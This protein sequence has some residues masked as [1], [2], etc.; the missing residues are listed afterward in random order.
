MVEFIA[1]IELGSSKITGIVGKKNSDESMQILAYAKENIPASIRKGT[2]YNINKTAQGLTAIINR[3][4]GQLQHSIAK[5]YVGIS[6][7]SLHTVENIVRRNL[8]SETVVSE[9]LIHE[10]IDENYGTQYA[11]ADILDVIPQE[12]KIGNDFQV[13]PVGVACNCIEGRFLNIITRSSV[14]KNLELSFELAKIDIADVFVTPL[15]TAAAI[16]TE[17]EKRSGCALVDFGADTTTVAIYKN[18]ILRFLTVLPLGSNNITR[19][20][21]SLQVEENEAEHIKIACGNAILEESDNE[22]GSMYV[23]ENKARSIKLSEL[24]NVVEARTEEI[25]ANV[26]NQ[27][28]YSDYGDKL[29]S[30]IVITGGGANLKN[31]D[32]ALR[33]KTGVFKIR[34]ANFVLNEIHEDENILPK[35]GTHNAL[36]GILFTGT[37]NCCRAEEPLPNEENKS[38]VATDLFRDDEALKKQQEEVENLKARKEE[39]DK[40]KTSKK[41]GKTKSKWLSGLKELSKDIFNDESME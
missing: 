32:E 4:E 37:E 23:T 17:S 10:I 29:I 38:T 16:L 18:K 40:K 3:L 28:Q 39:E 6:G 35:D 41:T 15:V 31:L 11:D 21:T 20:I 1:V 27:I 25:I 22:E 34:H 13:D 26:W 2:V 24:N 12:Y 7:Q 33:R 9:S 8:R 19:D 14:K 5:V 30:G 36:L